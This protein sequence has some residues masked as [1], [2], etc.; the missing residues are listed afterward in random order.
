MSTPEINDFSSTVWKALC[1]KWPEEPPDRYDYDRF[2]CHCAAR[3]RRIITLS[4]VARFSPAAI[5]SSFLNS[6]AI[7]ARCTICA[8]NWPKA[9]P[10]FIPPPYR[11]PGMAGIARLLSAGE[12]LIAREELRQAGSGGATHLAASAPAQC[13]PGSIQ[14]AESASARISDLRLEHKRRGTSRCISCSGGFGSGLLV[15]IERTARRRSP[16]RVSG[17]NTRF[18]EAPISCRTHRPRLHGVPR[19]TARARA[20]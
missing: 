17:P 12:L 6:R 16:S 15:R 1:R 11:R 18:E 9:L 5:P 7:R 14:F 8:A 2:I 20:S 10:V 3:D 13:R 4:G 19:E